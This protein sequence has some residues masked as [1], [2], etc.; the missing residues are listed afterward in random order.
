MGIVFGRADGAFPRLLNLVKFGLGV[1]P[2]ILEDSGFR[3]QYLTAATA[4]RDL[5]SLR[6]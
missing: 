2:K 5:L 3:F 4:I 6:I 1:Y